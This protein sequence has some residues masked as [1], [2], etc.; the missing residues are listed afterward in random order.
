MT[1]GDCSWPAGRKRRSWESIAAP[2]H[3]SS[4]LC[5]H[6][7]TGV[8]RKRKRD[9][10]CPPTFQPRPP[11]S[12]WALWPCPPSTEKLPQSSTPWCLGSS[13][14][15]PGMKGLGL[16]FKCPRSQALP[17]VGPVGQD[18]G[19]D[20]GKED[21][22]GQLVPARS[23]PKSC[24]LTPNHRQCLCLELRRQPLSPEPLRGGEMGV[25]DPKRRAKKN[26]ICAS[27][28]SPREQEDSGV[29]GSSRCGAELRSGTGPLLPPHYSQ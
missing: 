12:C 1:W 6:M 23:G 29:P 14:S 19:Q 15:G 9:R 27:Q 2:L 11:T 25:Q 28:V 8:L 10:P 3:P 5:V 17:S 20:Q 22:L 18:R 24:L 21:G 7:G 4:A 13:L 26:F 16:G